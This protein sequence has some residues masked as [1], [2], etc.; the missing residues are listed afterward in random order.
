[1]Q[2]LNLNA[3]VQQIQLW[4]SPRLTP[5]INKARAMWLRLSQRDQHILILGSILV[6]FMFLFLVIGS[7]IDLQNDLH[8]NLIKT[9]QQVAY[10]KTLT[11][12]LKDLSQITANEFSTPTADKIKGDITQLFDVKNPDVALVDKT[13]TISIPSARFERVMLFLDQLR[14]SYGIFPS[15]LQLT[16]ISPSGYVSFHATFNIED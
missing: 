12:R 14:K 6:G 4:L 10:T 1:M 15:E 11:T 5:L 7:A 13:L 8:N 2:R 3:S 16:R 9:E